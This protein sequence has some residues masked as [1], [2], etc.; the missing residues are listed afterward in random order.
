MN[1]FRDFVVKNN[2]K[3]HKQHDSNDNKNN[4]LC[5]IDRVVFFEVMSGLCACKYLE[6]GLYDHADIC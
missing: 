4:C 6:N 2:S 1:K 3:Q 5:C